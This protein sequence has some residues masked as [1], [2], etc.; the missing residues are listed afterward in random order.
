MRSAE[1]MYNWC[2]EQGYGKGFS[3]GT[4]LK[5]FQLIADTLSPGEEAIITFIGLHNYVSATK[6]DNNFAYAIT[7]KRIIMAQSRLLGP[8]IQTVSIE[9]INDITSISRLAYCVVTIDTIKETFNVAIVKPDG[10]QLASRLHDYFLE[11]KQK[12]TV[13]ISTQSAA[14]EIM[15]FK[16]LLDAGIISQ[17]EFDHKKKQ[18]LDL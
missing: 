14:D 4:A 12:K 1:A 13:A 9:Q 17:D 16:N 3:R 7:N 11:A 2:L 8:V 5:H 15:K 10:L 6:H 18:L